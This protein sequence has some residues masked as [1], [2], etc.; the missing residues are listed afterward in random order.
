METEKTGTV[1]YAVENTLLPDIYLLT[2]YITVLLEKLTGLELV[3]KFPA[4]HRTRRLITVLTSVRHLSLSWASLIQS[5]YTHPTSW[6]SVLI[7]PH[8]HLVLPN[9]LLPSGFP[10][11]TLYT[12]SPN[13]Y[14]PHAQSISFCSILSPAQF[15]VRSTYHLDPRYAIS[16]IRPLPRPS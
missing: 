5:I 16:Y 10:T 8:L 11:K 12:P 6:T 3:K 9:G 13:P 15:W 2:P 14:V 7:L 1:N 4:S